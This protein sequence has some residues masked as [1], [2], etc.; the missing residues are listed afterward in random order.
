M[1]PAFVVP[2]VWVFLDDDPLS[3]ANMKVKRLEREKVKEEE[4]E[5]AR[6]EYIKEAG[7]LAQSMERLADAVEAKSE[8]DSSKRP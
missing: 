7:N 8:R 3:M 4:L 5:K 1:V 6:N 2:A